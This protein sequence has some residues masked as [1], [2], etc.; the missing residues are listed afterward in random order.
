[1]GHKTNRVEA[2]RSMPRLQLATLLDKPASTL[3]EWRKR[4]GF[5]Y[6]ENP[7]R[8]ADPVDAIACVRWLA[9]FVADNAQHLRRVAEG[10]VNDDQQRLVAA[11]ADLAELELA[12]RRGDVVTLPDLLADVGAFADKIRGALELVGRLNPECQQIMMAAIDDAEREFARG[13]R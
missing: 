6:P 11:K 7:G 5:P 9:Q 3:I 2:L 13:T 12:K 1:M 10:Q 8:Q 4:W